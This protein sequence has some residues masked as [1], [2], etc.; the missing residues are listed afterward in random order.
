MCTAVA[1]HKIRSSQCESR[2]EHLKERADAK[3]HPTQHEAVQEE[4]TAEDILEECIEI[5]GKLLGT[6]SLIV[7]SWKKE[8]EK[9]ACGVNVQD[10]ESTKASA[11]PF[12]E[13][14]SSS[15]F[16]SRDSF[17]ETHNAQHEPSTLDHLQGNEQRCK[18][19]K[20][21]IEDDLD[22][23]AVRVAELLSAEQFGSLF[24]WTH[25]RDERR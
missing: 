20:N 3:T 18:M 22:D 15:S 6:D 10:P 14:R 19:V 17:S 13:G 25:H 24:R 4:E 2:T 23:F 5:Q 9:L 1:K 11:T 7:V 12:S 8:L 16:K 21:L